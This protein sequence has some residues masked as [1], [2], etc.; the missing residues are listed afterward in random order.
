MDVVCEF[1]TV[2]FGAEVA[3]ISCRVARSAIGLEAA[4]KWLCGKRLTGRLTSNSE[5]NQ[6]TLPGMDDAADSVSGAFDVK[7]FGVRPD[8]LTFGLAFAKQSVNKLDLISMCRRAGRIIIEK[9]EDLPDDSGDD[10]EKF[11]D[12]PDVGPRPLANQKALPLPDNLQAL[13]RDEGATKPLTDLCQWGMTK[14]K[15]DALA[16]S[17]GG[18]TIGHLEAFMKAKPEFWS[19]DLK[20]FGPG[21]VTKL[22]D[23]HLEFRR[24]FPMVDAEDR[25]DAEYAFSMGV[26]AATE[27][28]A[29]VHEYKP[30]GREAKA[31]EL[32]FA[33]VAAD[34]TD[35]VDGE[36][37]MRDDEPAETLEVD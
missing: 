32:G 14:A 4:D 2:S 28:R 21:W 33:S 10:D 31:F 1:G 17:V 25:K 37:D 27:K 36:L 9:A 18:K 22:Q 30:G 7:G 23:A 13:L 19:R 26:L 5:I 12:H 11:D 20:G 6:Q 35:D 15:C 16:E 29:A 34:E 8:V 24:Q 3:R